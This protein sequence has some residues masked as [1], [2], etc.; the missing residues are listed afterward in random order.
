MPYAR[1]ILRESGRGR[2]EG[3]N[4][5]ALRNLSGRKTCQARSIGDPIDPSD[6]SDACECAKREIR[7][8]RVQRSSLFLKAGVRVMPVTTRRTASTD[9]GDETVVPESVELPL[10]DLPEWAENTLQVVSFG[11]FTPRSAERRARSELLVLV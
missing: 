9:Q 3:G 7:R 10:L 6:L 8:E 5:K 1:L 11:A 2:E 4:R